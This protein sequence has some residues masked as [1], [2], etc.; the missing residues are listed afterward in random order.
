MHGAWPLTALG[1]LPVVLVGPVLLAG[2]R[3]LAARPVAT[4]R[5]VRAVFV[6]HLAQI[7]DRPPVRPVLVFGLHLATLVL[8]LMA[9][10]ALEAAHPLLTIFAFT[11]LVIQRQIMQ[12]IRPKEET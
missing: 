9:A 8:M 12:G 2:L 10:L 1:L 7:L 4:P 3:I 5:D 6:Q 11:P